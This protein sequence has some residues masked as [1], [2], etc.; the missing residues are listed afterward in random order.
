MAFRDEKRTLIQ[1]LEYVGRLLEELLEYI[2]EDRELFASAWYGE[3]KPRLQLLTNNI[4]D[5]PD[6]YDSRWSEFQLRG[7]TGE[8]L[9]LKR[10]RLAA[11]SKKGALGK[12]LDLINSILGSIPGADPIKEFKEL[13]EEVLEDNPNASARAIFE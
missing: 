9:R 11:V 4:N 5:I 13:T 2:P 12:I 7:L 1:I 10:A 8:Q 6:E 3:V